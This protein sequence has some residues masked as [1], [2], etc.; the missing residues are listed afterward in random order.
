MQ[1]IFFKALNQNLKKST[2]Q[3]ILQKQRDI[4]C[5]KINGYIDNLQT[6]LL[7]KNRSKSIK[8]D[9]LANLS[10]SSILSNSFECKKKKRIR[11]AT[12]REKITKRKI[13]SRNFLIFCI[14]LS[15]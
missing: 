1:R 7:E 6:H 2:S 9:F 15:L 11:P 10:D 14:S 3:S 5:N 13:E 8:S 12:Q 4:L